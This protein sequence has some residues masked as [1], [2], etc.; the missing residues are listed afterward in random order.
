MPVKSIHA[1]DQRSTAIRRSRTR[2]IEIGNIL[3]GESLHANLQVRRLSRF[4]AE[5][6][7]F[8]SG[9]PAKIPVIFDH[10]SLLGHYRSRGQCKGDSSRFMIQFTPL[11]VLLMVS[12]AISCSP[13]QAERSLSGKSNCESKCSAYHSRSSSPH[14]SSEHTSPQ[15]ALRQQN[16]Q[17][18]NIDGRNG[19]QAVSLTH[20]ASWKCDG[21]RS[22]HSDPLHH[23]I[24]SAASV[25]VLLCRWHA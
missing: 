4:A 7:T 24:S 5:D 2:G 1:V 13:L 22:L 14:W 16:R 21:W 23:H 9:Q 8:P 3:T 25:Q 12:W 10:R 17:L 19:A 15:Q 20:V 6:K 18:P 11:T